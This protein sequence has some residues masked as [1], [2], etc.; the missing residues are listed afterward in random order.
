M[1]KFS[2]GAPVSCQ[3]HGLGMA[4]VRITSSGW[5]RGERRQRG[6]TRVGLRPRARVRGGRQAART[7]VVWKRSSALRSKATRLVGGTGAALRMASMWTE[8]RGERGGASRVHCGHRA[9][10]DRPHM[11]PSWPTASRLSH[12]RALAISRARARGGS[13]PRCAH[14]TSPSCCGWRTAWP[15]CPVQC[16][17]PT[18]VRAFSDTGR[19]MAVAGQRA[20]L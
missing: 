6:R 7:S 9:R 11:T 18:T 17:R 4:S 3:S 12:R 10:S 13:V 2:K 1:M 5:V 14:Q 20:C 19:R 8:V 16:C 15:P